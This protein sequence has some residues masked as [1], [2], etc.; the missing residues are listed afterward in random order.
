MSVVWLNGALLA[1]DAAR[2]DPADRGFT[3]GDGLFETIAVMTAKPLHFSAHL[4]RMAEGAAILRIPFEPP[5]AARAVMEVIAVNS[6]FA[7]QGVLRLT[8]SR[9][10]GARGLLPQAAPQPTL[11]AV[12]QPM[13]PPLPPAKLCIAQSTR[14]NHL[15]PLSR[16]KSLNYLDGI[17]ARQEAADRA[18]DDAILRNGVGL[19]I[20]TTIANFAICRDGAWVTPL[21]DDGALPGIARALLI[22]NRIWREA[23]ITLADLAETESLL[24]VNSLGCRI[25]ASLDGRALTTDLAAQSTAQSFILPG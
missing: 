22:E 20:E 4:S 9:G 14:R 17:L 19:P 21:A 6:A 23:R 11:L 16:I 10:P 2:I 5:M 24:L 1:D 13:P 25:A 3:L 15:S 8:L 18:C 12:L 7:V